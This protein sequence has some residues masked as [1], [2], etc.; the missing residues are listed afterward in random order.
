MSGISD[1]N[2]WET[3]FLKWFQTMRAFHRGM[4]MVI[5]HQLSKPRAIDVAF[6]AMNVTEKEPPSDRLTKTLDVVLQLN[7]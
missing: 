5:E 7:K 1:A 2:L 4:L 3:N 6:Q